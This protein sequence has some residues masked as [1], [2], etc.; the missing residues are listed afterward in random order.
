MSE[1]T[2]IP[3]STGPCCMISLWKLMT[4]PGIPTAYA[5]VARTFTISEPSR[6]FVGQV[7]CK[8]EGMNAAQ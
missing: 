1:Y 6:H 2:H 7:S 4:S 8:N 3:V 5:E